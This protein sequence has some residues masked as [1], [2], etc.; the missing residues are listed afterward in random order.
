MDRSAVCFGLVL[1]GAA[2]A[3]GAARAQSASAPEPVQAA[4]KFLSKIFG[5]AAS[6]AGPAL[7]VQAES[8][9]KPAAPPTGK[10]ASG[11][12][13]G[14]PLTPNAAALNELRVDRQCQKVEENFDVWQKAMAYGGT[15][16]QLRLQVLLDSDF[17]QDQ[18]SPSDREMMRYLAY[19]TVWIPSSLEANVGRLYAAVSKSGDDNAVAASGRTQRRALERL[20]TRLGEVK[21]GIPGFPGDARLVFDPALSDG[22]FARVGGLVVVSSRFLGLMDESDP[23]RDVVFAHELSHLYKRH[24]IKE[25]Q[26]RMV[27]SAA[28]FSLAK[29]LLGR[30]LPSA[31]TSVVPDFIYYAQTA[32]ELF[33]WVRESNLA[34]TRDQEL[35]ADAC[36]LNWL[37]ALNVPPR[38]AWRSFETVLAGAPD[39]AVGYESLHPSPVERAKNIEQALGK[40][41]APGAPTQKRPT[42]KAP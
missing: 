24:T 19:T 15:E 9:A 29:K 35:E 10:A 28:G 33:T 34:Y 8:G 17:K 3:G 32:S 20:A 41:S 16:A 39:P 14:K 12:A 1:A 38:D 26:Y 22:A 42:T 30:S 23:V 18:L 27:T 6:A 37:S 25:M 36:A 2:L 11:I 13:A 7:P 4:Q 31:K 5:P 21:G 40:S